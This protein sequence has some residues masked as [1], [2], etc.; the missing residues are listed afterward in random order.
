MN[1]KTILPLALGLIITLSACKES[2]LE[3]KQNKSLVIPTTLKDYQ[4]LMDNTAVMNGPSGHTLGIIGADEYFLTDAIYNALPQPHLKTIYSWDKDPYPNTEVDD[5]NYNYWHIL[6]ANTALSGAEKLKNSS[7]VEALN[8]LKG[9]ALF[10]RGLN[11]YQLAQTFCKPYHATTA[12]T[13]PGI[14]L[15]LEEDINLTV[16]RGTLQ[17]SYHQIISDLEKAAALLPANPIVK[18]RP[19]KAAAY[20]MLAK[21]YLQMGEYEK[22]LEQA[23]KYLNIKSELLDFNTVDLSPRYPF[24]DFNTNVEV[25]FVLSPL[26]NA[27]TGTT[28]VNILPAL[29]NSYAANDLR[30][31]AYFL[32]NTDGR[33]IFK[34]SYRA[35]GGFFTG[36]ATDELYLIRAECFA[37]TNQTEKA[38]QDLNTLRKNRYA[39]ASYADVRAADANAALKLVIAERRKELLFRGTRWEDLRRLNQEAEFAITLTRTINGITSMLAPNDNRYTWPVPDKEI[40]L[41]NLI[42][43]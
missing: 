9:C 35:S 36:I 11:F 1:I 32:N 17:Q 4:G 10:H 37:R 33:V 15:R 7:D 6:Y 22:V 24:T 26:N 8:N 5:W 3:L 34:G 39:K 25:I 42:Q 23:N 19:G 31:Q 2:F 40:T 28:R 30:K 20:A 21:T 27:V 12:S 29:I 14:P 18:F 16:G 43:N 13:D 38:L 41:S